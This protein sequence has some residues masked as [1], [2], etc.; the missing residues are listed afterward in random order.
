MIY[1]KAEEVMEK[2]L[3]QRLYRYQTGIKTLMK[4]SNFAFN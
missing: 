4:S 3:E 1:D 2:H